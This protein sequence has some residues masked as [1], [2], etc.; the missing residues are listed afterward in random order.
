MSSESAIKFFAAAATDLCLAPALCVVARHRRHFELFIGSFHLISSLLFNV[1]NALSARFFLREDQWHFISDVMSLTYVCLLLIHLMG[2]IDENTNIMLRYTAFAS[3]WV[4]KLRDAWDSGF[5]EEILIAAYVLMALGIVMS[6]K[7]RD[8]NTGL[9]TRGIVLI[10]G[11]LICFYL[12]MRESPDIKEGQDPHKLLMGTG[13][14][15]AGAAWYFLWQ[16][17]P[18]RDGSRRK[19]FDGDGTRAQEE[20]AKVTASAFV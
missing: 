4:F 14:I 20:A 6:R 3:A 18:V 19:K 17:V 7:T 1:S 5:W 9:L 12:E 10:A 2:N 11:A 8:F 15:L 13:H 16:A